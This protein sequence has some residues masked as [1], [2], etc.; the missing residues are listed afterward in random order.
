M[1][2]IIIIHNVHT[3]PHVRT[4]APRKYDD[5]KGCR[6]NEVLATNNPVRAYRCVCA[7]PRDSDITTTV[8]T[9]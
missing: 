2:I 7:R 8:L 1:I 3:N 5:Y 6:G 4:N 9:I